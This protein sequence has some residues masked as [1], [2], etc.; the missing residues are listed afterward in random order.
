MECR[1]EGEPAQGPDEWK[2]C[3]LCKALGHKSVTAGAEARPNEC[4]MRL[5]YCKVLRR[6]SLRTHDQSCAGETIGRQVTSLGLFGK[7]K[8]RAKEAKKGAP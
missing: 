4:G 6:K 8:H 3:D 2:Q 7:P 1:L 5:S